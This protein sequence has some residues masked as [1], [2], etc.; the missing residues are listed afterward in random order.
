MLNFAQTAGGIGKETAFAFGEAGVKAVI[1]A[2]INEQGA[3]ET[4]EQSKKHASHPDYTATVIKVDAVD[5]D[6]M[7]NMVEV[8]VKEHGPIDYSVNSAEV[9]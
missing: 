7:S 8:A 5:E 2:D 4:A 3:S 6:S 9:S 1:F